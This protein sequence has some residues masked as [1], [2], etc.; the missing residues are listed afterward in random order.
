MNRY[1]RCHRHDLQDHPRHHHQR[2]Y[3]DK[4]EEEEEESQIPLQSVTPLGVTPLSVTPP[5]PHPA[6]TCQKAQR[7]V[8]MCMSALCAWKIRGMFASNVDIVLFVRYALSHTHLSMQKYVVSALQ[9]C[10]KLLM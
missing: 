2:I 1:S 7:K 9:T 4:L 6:A 10:L 8:F 3:A 5:L